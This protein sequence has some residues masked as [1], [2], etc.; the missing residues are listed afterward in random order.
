MIPAD[1]VLMFG[2]E[3]VEN[4]DAGADWPGGRLEGGTG[5]AISCL[6][7]SLSP[8]GHHCT[9]TH[10]KVGFSSG[11]ALVLLCHSGN[12]YNQVL[13][14]AASGSYLTIFRTFTLQQL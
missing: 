3:N 2:L 1:W 11:S 10:L 14:I 7:T 4:Q 6:V 9:Q 5:L 13:V 12:N 8:K